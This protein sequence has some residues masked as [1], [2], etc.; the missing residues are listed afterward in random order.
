MFTGFS[1]ELVVLGDA[2]IY[3]RYAGNGPP[4]LLLHGHPRTHATWY[5]VAERLVAQHTV[6]CPDLRGYGRSSKPMSRADHSQQ[7]KRAMAHDMLELMAHLGHKSFH[8][9]G[10]DRG[11][12]RGLPAGDG[13]SARG[14]TPDR[15]GRRAHPGRPR[16]LQQPL[17]R[18]VVALVLLCAARQ[19]RACHQRRSERVVWR[20]PSQ[21]STDWGSVERLP[22]CDPRPADGSLYVGGLSCGP[23]CGLPA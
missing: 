20:Q 11:G 1:S 13:S 7:S 10:H 14:E 16:A 12:L 23:G 5:R 4:I 18:L 19:A 9:V 22:G 2:S 8:A 3:V 15:D 17:C 6:V 21:A